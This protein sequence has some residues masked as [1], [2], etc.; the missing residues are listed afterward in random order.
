SVVQRP[1]PPSAVAAILGA[2][3]DRLDSSRQRLV[4]YDATSDGARPGRVLV[5]RPDLTIEVRGASAT[6]R[7]AAGERDDAT[8]VLSW[9]DSSA[10][11]AQYARALIIRAFMR[12][13][14]SRDL[15]AAR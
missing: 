7:A 2:F 11:R 14:L 15:Q 12:K 5:T 9:S 8:A 3:R 1:W 6:G 4:L 13:N 10:D